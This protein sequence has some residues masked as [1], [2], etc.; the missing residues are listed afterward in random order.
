MQVVEFRMQPPRRGGQCRVSQT[1]LQED[2]MNVWLTRRWV[3]DKDL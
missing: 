1:E 2:P 3:I